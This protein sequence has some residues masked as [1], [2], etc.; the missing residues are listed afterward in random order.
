MALWAPH[1]VASGRGKG[2]NRRDRFVTDVGSRMRTWIHRRAAPAGLAGPCEG[3]CASSMRRCNASSF[4]RLRELTGSSGQRHAN[5]GEH[6]AHLLAPVSAAEDTMSHYLQRW[7]VCRRWEASDQGS[8]W[9]SQRSSHLWQ[10]GFF[11]FQQAGADTESVVSTEQFLPDRLPR[12][13]TEDP[14]V[15]E[16]CDE[17]IPRREGMLPGRVVKYVCCPNRWG[18][19][20]SHRHPFAASRWK[21]ASMVPSATASHPTISPV[22]LSSSRRSAA[23]RS[24]GSLRS[25]GPGT[26]LSQD[27]A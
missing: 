14:M 13:V 5:T 23:P 20:A 4:V 21:R 27:R 19:S 22:Q 16:G 24:V 10:R 15:V 12:V 2:A 1:R 18:T 7:Q 11:E 8:S 26:S 3:V 25:R 9:R 17:V 6:R